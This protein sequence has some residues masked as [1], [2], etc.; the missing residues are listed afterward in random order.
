MTSG[1]NPMD[2]LKH[3]RKNPYNSR[4][5]LFGNS[6]KVFSSPKTYGQ[7]PVQKLQR[8]CKVPFKDTT[9]TTF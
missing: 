8:N 1:T 2:V 9:Y 4:S 6:K 5:C 3:D 7:Q